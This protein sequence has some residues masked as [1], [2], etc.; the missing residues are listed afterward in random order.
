[1]EKNFENES[2]SKSVKKKKFLARGSGTAGGRKGYEKNQ[3]KSS[4]TDS[5]KDLGGEQQQ[6]ERYKKQ[7]SSNQNEF[8]VGQSLH[9]EQD[10]KSPRLPNLA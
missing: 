10:N 9:S 2:K 6:Q 7:R 5:N 3:P 8:D 1:M 4:N